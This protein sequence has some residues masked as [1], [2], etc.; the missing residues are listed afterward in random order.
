MRYSLTIFTCI[1][2]DDFYL[3]FAYSVIFFAYGTFHC[4]ELKLRIF[5]AFTTNLLEMV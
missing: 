5:Y 3:C 4:F 2:K 1:L